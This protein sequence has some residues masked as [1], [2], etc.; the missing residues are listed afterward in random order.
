MGE[1]FFGWRGFDV[2]QVIF[3]PLQTIALGFALNIE[4]L[5]CNAYRR[6]ALKRGKH[7]FHIKFQNF[8][9]LSFQV[10]IRNYHNIY[11]QSRTTIYFY[12]FIVCILA[13]YAFQSINNKI[14]QI[15]DKYRILR[16]SAY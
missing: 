8:V 11:L 1:I 2:C 10:T 15:S 5:K 7:L 14:G 12:F 3:T 13:P 9:I 6:A 4:A 16:C